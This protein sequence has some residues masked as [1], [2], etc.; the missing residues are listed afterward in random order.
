[1]QNLH[2]F[3]IKAHYFFDACKIFQGDLSHFL[4]GARITQALFNNK[5]F[6]Q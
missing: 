6:N 4:G 5:H 3:L 2:F 1:M